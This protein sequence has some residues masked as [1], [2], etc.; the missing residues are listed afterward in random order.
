MSMRDWAKRE[1]EIACKIHTEDDG[2]FAAC[3]ESA[4]KAYDSLLECEHSGASFYTTRSILKR[5]LYELPLTEIEDVPENWDY[6]TSEDDYD[7]Y[8]SLRMPSLFKY[9][10]KNGEIKYKDQN[11]VVCRD[12]L[13]N[14]S[15][16]YGLAEQIVDEMFPIEMPYR[17]D[18]GDEYIVY[19]ELFS[20]T[21]EPGVFNTVGIFYI[22]TPDKK[23]V[24][25]NRYYAE[26]DSGE[27]HPIKAG[28]YLDRKEL[29]S[30]ATR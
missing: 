21:G 8:I 19:T 9:V 18:Y 14:T 27:M 3:C 7:L 12:L 30:E 22:M 13:T 25:V 26:D 2:Y 4:L 20:T 11:R 28:E 1:C 6:I 17:P 15:H 5:L 10:Y 29:F 24:D 16:H 23:R